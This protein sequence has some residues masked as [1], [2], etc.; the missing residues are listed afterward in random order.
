MKKSTKNL[1]M[2]PCVVCKEDMPELRKEKFG[3]LNCVNCSTV[4]PKRAVITTGGSGD[5][6]WN[7]IQILS[8]ED[9]ES[10]ERQ[11]ELARKIKFGDNAE[12]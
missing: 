8:A 10:F 5:H 7:D 2:I 4:K 1:K 3:Y 9:A 6:T 12:S 11:Q